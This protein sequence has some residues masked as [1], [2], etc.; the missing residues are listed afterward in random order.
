MTL[1]SY[2]AWVLRRI[3]GGVAIDGDIDG[4]A[5]G[6]RPV[7]EKL[8]ACPLEDRGTLMDWYLM[9]RSDGDAIFRA[10]SDAV[11]S[12][13]APPGEAAEADPSATLADV[14]R[15]DG[16]RSWPWPGWLPRASLTA[17]ASDPGIGK[18]LLAMTLSREIWRGS[19]WP[20]GQ[21]PT[22]PQGTRTLWVP[23][24]QHFGQLVEVAAAYGLPP[25]AIV[26]NGSP[27]DP[28]GRLFLD[29]I[30]SIEALR[31]RV[32]RHTPALVVIDTVGMTTDRNL[33]KP[34]EARQY[35]EPLMKIANE[36]RT[37]F[38]LLTHLSKDSQQA[39]GRRIV[40]ASRVVWKLT[41]PDPEGQPD[42][43][44]LWVDKSYALKPPALGMTIAAEGCT[45]DAQPPEGPS[46][47]KGGRAP[48]KLE[49]CKQWL[50][51]R[52]TPLAVP[53]A[54]LRSGAEERGFSPT[55]LYAAK[56]GIGA[57]E[58]LIEK[59]K[60]WKLPVGR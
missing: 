26:L 21:P 14:C 5:A 24:D 10:V 57:D 19:T 41:Q 4:M 6:W 34:E 39:L 59:R 38:L 17:L 42:R 55:V 25:E 13:P 1:T 33:G 3:L 16:D 45:F 35:F 40:G 54:E 27:D 22:F 47:D 37:S 2:E 20:D 36:H 52:L 18:T 32:I 43:R 48:A 49:A 15:L 60:W 53:V 23:G 51:E 50:L 30:E 7:A 9:A 28:T 44:K 56:V 8:L 11:P 58:Y 29:D 46:K 31:R 12:A